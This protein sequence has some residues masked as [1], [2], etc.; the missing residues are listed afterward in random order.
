MGRNLKRTV[1]YAENRLVKVGPASLFYRQMRFQVIKCEV[2]HE[3]A[4]TE[5]RDAVTR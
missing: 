2:A 4:A 5:F 1:G 3:A